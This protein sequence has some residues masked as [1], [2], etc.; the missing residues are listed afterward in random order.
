MLMGSCSP[1]G[2]GE[3]P[4]AGYATH[5]ETGRLAWRPVSKARYGACIDATRWEMSSES[6]G[7]ASYRPPLGCGYSGNQYWRVW[8]VN[9]LAANMDDFECIARFSDKAAAADGHRYSPVLNGFPRETE[10]YRCE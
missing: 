8:L 3:N 5:K 2:S 1:S 4:W 10:S 6:A 9:Q 7:A